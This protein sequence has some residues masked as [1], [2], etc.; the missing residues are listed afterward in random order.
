MDHLLENYN[1][2]LPEHLIASRPA[3][4]RHS[5]KLM[6]YD[7]RTGEVH[8]TSFDN[9]HQ[10]LPQNSCMVFNQSKVFPCRLRG[11]KS[12]G[13]SVEVF[14]LSLEPTDGDAY[15]CLVKTT[16]KKKIGEKYYFDGGLEAQLVGHHEREDSGSFLVKFSTGELLTWL[17]D[18]AMIPI[19]PYIRKGESD[20][21]DRSDYQTI[22]AKNPGSVAAPT[23]GLH[24]TE[25]VLS[26]LESKKIDTAFVNLHVG[27]GTFSKVGVEN[28]HDHKMHHESYFVDSENLEKIS[29]RKG[30][31]VA[32]GTTSLRVLESSYNIDMNPAEMYSTDIF[33]H[34]GVDVKSIKA[35]VTNFHLPKSSLL[36]LVSALIGREK[37]LEL[38]REAIENEYRFFSYGDGMLILLDRGELGE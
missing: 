33:L 4:P 27:L 20:L 8:H 35:L 34:P 23:A 29:S 19:P 38:Y 25:L 13:G 5:S 1:Y 10:F 22:Y 9:I 30:S 37:T 31:L 18:Y 24:F 11:K 36:M 16:K 12:T 17:E 14:L 6:I 26:N 21:R 2:H 15:P 7:Q 28:I 32:V 3:V